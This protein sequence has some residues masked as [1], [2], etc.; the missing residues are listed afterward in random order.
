MMRTFLLSSAICIALDG[1]VGGST[2]TSAEDKE[3][4]KAYVLD[5]APE[6]PTKLEIDFDGKVKL[7]GY[8]IEPT[9]IVRPNGRVKITM[10]WLSVKKLDEGW[11]LFTHI[12]DGSGERILN[13]DNV[14][15]IREWKGE[16]QVLGPSAWMAGKVYADEQEFTIP[17]NVRTD[18]I[19]VT[20]GIWKENDRL[21]IVSGP[22]D[23][24]NRGIVANISTGGP[25]AP[26][27][28]A[29]LSTTR[30]PAL[31]LDKLDK[32]VKI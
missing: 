15:P 12:L 18:K 2:D 8:K 31:R 10:Y 26:A 27:P 28:S 9:G 16:K 23:R 17:G 20:T 7:L 3:R 6:L 29:D 32:G 25:A 22:H 11:N 4:L 14:G 19:Q 13:I 24:E 21:K 1:C 30:V 5:K